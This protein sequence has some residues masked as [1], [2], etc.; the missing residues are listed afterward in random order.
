MSLQLDVLYLGQNKIA[1]FV[2][3]PKYDKQH[4]S[5]KKIQHLSWLCRALYPSPLLLLSL[6][7][8]PCIWIWISLQVSDVRVTGVSSRHGQE[9]QF[10][11]VWVSS[12]HFLKYLWTGFFSPF[13]TKF[14]SWLWVVISK[15]KCLVCI[16]VWLPCI[17][18]K[19]LSVLNSTCPVNW[20]FISWIYCCLNISPQASAYFILIGKCNYLC[21]TGVSVSC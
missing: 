18:E 19:V 15:S 8:V 16:C 20:N 17:L 7:L 1:V 4:S 13:I 5:M 11:Y 14:F 3:Q 21:L 6:F 9:L 12:P 2:L 10:Y